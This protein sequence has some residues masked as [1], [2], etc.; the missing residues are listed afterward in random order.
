MVI[1][2]YDKVRLTSGL[3]ARIVEVLERGKA[4]LA[5]VELGDGEFTTKFV[6]DAEIDSLFVETESKYAGA[7]ILG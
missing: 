4:Y 1:Q 7:R 6:N 3:V 5:D 2:Q